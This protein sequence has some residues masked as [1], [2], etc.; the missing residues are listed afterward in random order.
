MV[1]V[2]TQER[3]TMT[4]A[5]KFRRKIQLVRSLL[6]KQRMFYEDLSPV[7]ECIVLVIDGEIQVCKR[8]A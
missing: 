5:R 6:P 8:F 4:A 7:S 2:L 3:V 1:F